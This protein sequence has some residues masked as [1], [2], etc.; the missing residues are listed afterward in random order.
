[1]NSSFSFYCFRLFIRDRWSGIERLALCEEI[2][3]DIFWSVNYLSL[4]ML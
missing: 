1:M 2:V 4:L 3:S